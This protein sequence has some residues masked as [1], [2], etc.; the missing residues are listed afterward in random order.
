MAINAQQVRRAFTKKDKTKKGISTGRGDIGIFED[1]TKPHPRALPAACTLYQV[2]GWLLVSGQGV[3]HTNKSPL[4]L[5][6][7]GRAR[8]GY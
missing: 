8:D 1:V 6:Y 7:D 5:N 2:I 4:M 3:P